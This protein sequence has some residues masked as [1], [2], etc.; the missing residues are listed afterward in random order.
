[1]VYLGDMKIDQT[2]RGGRTLL[3]LVEAMRQWVG[4]RAEAAFA[5]VMDGTSATPARYTGRLGIPLFSELGKIIV[6]HLP[7]S[8]IQDHPDIG[9]T[10]TAERGSVCYA[11]LTAGKYACPDGN[12]AARS[13]MEPV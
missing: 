12:T 9:W 4:T 13:E 2:V 3:R 10:T 7:T 11:R 5:V 6:L 1:M 8:V